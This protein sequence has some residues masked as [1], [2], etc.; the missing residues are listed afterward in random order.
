M[1]GPEKYKLR[2]TKKREISEGPQD[3]RF[4]CLC[5]RRKLAVA[6]CSTV[7]AFVRTSYP[8]KPSSS[9]VSIAENQF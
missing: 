8:S 7:F 3:E 1:D 4:P 9:P 6:T 5:S 2:R